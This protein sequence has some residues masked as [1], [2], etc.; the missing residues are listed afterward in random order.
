MKV[1]WEE[2]QIHIK[3]GTVQTMEVLGWSVDP[4]DR[5]TLIQTIG[6]VAVQ[7][8]GHIEEGDKITCTVT[9]HRE[10]APTLYQ[11]WHNRELVNVEDEGG[12]IYENMRV[13]VK[14][15]QY[16]KGFKKYLQADLEF[17]RV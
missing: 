3:I 1:R 14:K 15:Y 16:L 10:D 2:I 11:Y 13:R 6:G 5:Q 4:D 9:F 7:D 12:K 17:W 8:F